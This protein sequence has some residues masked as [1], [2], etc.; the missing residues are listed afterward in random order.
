MKHLVLLVLGMLL[1]SCG[2]ELMKNESLEN[3]Q[4][5]T[6][7]CN[8]RF[9][10]KEDSIGNS[11]ALVYLPLAIVNS[12]GGDL[13]YPQTNLEVKLI[14]ELQIRDQDNNLIFENFSF[15]PN[16]ADEGWNGRVNGVIQDGKYL[17]IIKLT[18]LDGSQLNLEGV[19]CMLECSN[20]DYFDRGLNLE[21]CFW[22][23]Q[24]DGNGGFD[25]TLVGPDLIGCF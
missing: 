6:D 17:V 7:C 5:P 14:D 9:T 4:F 23:S 3:F 8:Q 16:V 13:F 21:N 19:I 2:E 15:L 12:E 25:A 22:E 1:F 10:I 18:A 24:H 20:R 11:G